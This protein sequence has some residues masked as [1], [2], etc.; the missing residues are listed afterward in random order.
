MSLYVRERPRTAGFRHDDLR[1]S[2]A[3]GYTTAG[4]AADS[5]WFW[6]RRTRRLG[7]GREVDTTMEPHG[8]FPGQVRDDELSWVSI[9]RWLILLLAQWIG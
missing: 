3:S 1:L 2:G 9:V 7:R 5:S 6:P 4:S 8:S